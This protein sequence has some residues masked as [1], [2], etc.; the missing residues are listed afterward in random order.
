MFSDAATA[1]VAPPDTTAGTVVAPGA[2]DADV[3]ADSND[4]WNCERNDAMSASVKPADK[5]R[6][7]PCGAGSVEGWWIACDYQKKKKKKKR[8]ISNG[9]PNIYLSIYLYIYIHIT[10]KERL[11]KRENTGSEVVPR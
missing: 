10:D 8:L 4:P 5:R 7:K 1:A 3:G 11:Q 2:I 6:S 9:F